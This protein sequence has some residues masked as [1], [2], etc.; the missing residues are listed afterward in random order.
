VLKARTEQEIDA[1]FAALVKLGAGALLVGPDGFFFDRREQFA[2]LTKRFAMPA[3]FDLREFVEAGGLFS[4][5]ANLSEVYRE[6]GTYTGKILGGAKAAD[7]PV[8]QSA[9]FDLVINAQTAKNLGL[10]IPQSLL[11]RT[12]EVIQ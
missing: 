8:L 3:S 2:E 12:N 9:T 1:A 5:G 4:Y 11:V 7:L 6:A 10:T